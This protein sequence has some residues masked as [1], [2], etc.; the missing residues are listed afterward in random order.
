MQD[1]EVVHGTR[2]VLRRSVDS[3]FR[4]LSRRITCPI[5]LY[6]LFWIYRK[7][8]LIFLSEIAEKLLEHRKICLKFVKNIV[9]FCRAVVFLLFPHGK[10]KKIKC[11]NFSEKNSLKSIGFSLVFFPANLTCRNRIEDNGWP[12]I[13][14]H[15]G[16]L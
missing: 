7:S 8:N 6:V 15:E 16:Y 4:L 12:C 9:N 1:F 13:Y 11:E 2:T 10:L 3:G 14:C 5:V